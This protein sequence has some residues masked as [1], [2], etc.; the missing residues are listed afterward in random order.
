MIKKLFGKDDS[1]KEMLPDPTHLEHA[2][3][4]IALGNSDVEWITLADFDGLFVSSF[5]SQPKVAT[6]TISAMGAAMSAL[7]ERIS[8]ELKDGEFQYILIAGTNGISMAIELN[9]K[10]LLAIGL[11]AEVSIGDFLIQLQGTCLPRLMEILP[12]EQFAR[13]SG[14]GRE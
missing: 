9:S 5:P 12:G 13:L 1:S 11:E 14:I 7:G 3:A 6:D 2:L 10:Y 8:S 4:E